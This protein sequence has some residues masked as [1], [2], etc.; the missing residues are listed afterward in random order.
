MIQEAGVVQEAVEIWGV[1][2]YSLQPNPRFGGDFGE[3][4][5]GTRAN[6]EL[7]LEDHFTG[8]RM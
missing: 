7:G 1:T 3:L 6:E 8:L 4:R 2:I 5:A